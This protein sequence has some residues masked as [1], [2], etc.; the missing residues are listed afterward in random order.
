MPF[1]RLTDNY[2]DDPK[3][4]ALSDGAYRLWHNLLAYCRRMQ[5]DGLIPKSIMLGQ[6]H[7]RS[8][9]LDELMQIQP[10]ETEPLLTKVDSFGFKMTNYLKWNATKD[11]EN[12]RRASSKERMRAMRERRIHP[13]VPP[14]L[15]RNTENVTASH[16]P[17]TSV[18]VLDMDR[19]RIGSSSEKGSGEKPSRSWRQGSGAMG[20]ELPRAHLRH[21]VCG[22]VCLQ[23]TQFARFVA[24]FGGPQA[25]A[26][27]AVQRWAEA[28]LEAWSTPPLADRE[29]GENDFQF[30]DTRWAEWRSPTAKASA[31]PSIEADAEAVRAILRK[32]GAL[33]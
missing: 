28:V 19:D 32:Q 4:D 33:S 23:E 25:E 22:R 7:Y 12:E 18:H 10:F 8:K 30:W 11:E 3:I 13:G 29:I 26:F 14:P 5:T 9:R 20:A 15:Q 6:K 2:N 27:T 21:A 31:S 16:P 1:I 24:K 17:V